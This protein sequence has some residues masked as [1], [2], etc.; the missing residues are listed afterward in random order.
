MHAYVISAAA[1]AELLS[2]MWQVLATLAIGG[3]VLVVILAFIEPG[4]LV[5]RRP[6]PRKPRS[7]QSASVDAS[8]TDPELQSTP[9]SFDERADH[10]E[11]NR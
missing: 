10:R 9:A 5:K 8:L 6:F 11:D 7:Q 1:A 2:T 4:P 3:L